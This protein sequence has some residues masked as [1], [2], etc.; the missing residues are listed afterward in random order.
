[1]GYD[2]SNFYYFFLIIWI[3]ILAY[4]ARYLENNHGVKHHINGAIQLVRADQEKFD[5]DETYLQTYQGLD[6]DY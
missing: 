5:D 6:E 2:V 1:M 3:G 4:T